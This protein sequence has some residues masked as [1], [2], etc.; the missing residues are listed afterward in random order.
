MCLTYPD[1]RLW[2][3]CFPGTYMMVHKPRE[4][5]PKPLHPSWRLTQVLWSQKS[6]QRSSSVKPYMPVI[7]QCVETALSTPWV[8]CIFCSVPI[9]SPSRYSS[10]KRYWMVDRMVFL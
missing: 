1:F 2:F 5:H 7:L 8:D 6:G 10:Q 4:P 9:P 3:R